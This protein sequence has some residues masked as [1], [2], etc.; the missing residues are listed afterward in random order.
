MTEIIDA[1]LDTTDDT[2]AVT[3]A[4]RKRKRKTKTKETPS[5]KE[6]NNF[7]GSS[8]DSDPTSDGDSVEITLEEV[9]DS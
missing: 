3:K 9:S 6:D 7:V 8:S 5:D 2:K 1:E 4:V